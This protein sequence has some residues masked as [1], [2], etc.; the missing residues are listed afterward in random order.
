MGENKLFL[1]FFAAVLLMILYSLVKFRRYWKK[2]EL[3]VSLYWIFQVMLLGSLILKFIGKLR[4]DNALMMT[5]ASFI[6]STYLIM[7]VY[8]AVFFVIGDIISLIAK[9][10]KKNESRF[11]RF[12]RGRKYIVLMF[13]TTF[14]IAVIGYVNM[15]IIRQT[16]YSVEINKISKNESLSIAMLSDLHIGTGVTKG[17]ID[18]IV[19]EIN[20]MNVDVVFLIGDIIDDGTTDDEIDY[21]SNRFSDI[22]SKYGIYFVNGNHE[23][24]TNRDLSDVY[25]K[26]GITILEDD[27]VTIA[28]DITVYG[29]KDLSQD[30]KDIEELSELLKENN[31]SKAYP[32]IVLNHQPRELQQISQ[33]DVDLTL[34]GHTHGEQFPLTSRL[35]SRFNDFAYGEKKY[36]N[37]TAIVSSGT[38][39]WGV[40]YKFPAKSEIVRIELKFK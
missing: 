18:K 19:D 39:G 37:M 10:T 35:V 26:A 15:G 28:D 25:E 27:L 4:V 5:V 3:P 29:R 2:L 16:D 32:I 34:C 36:D 9:L 13:I 23:G 17:G 24:Y 38:G 33:A 20:D 14:T 8:S 6:N 31:I 7:V 22:N 21:M 12:V 1:F 40:H 30:P 11:V